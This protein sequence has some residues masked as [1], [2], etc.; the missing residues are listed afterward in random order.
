MI[1]ALRGEIRENLA[2]AWLRIRDL[3]SRSA[4]RNRLRHRRR[5]ALALRLAAVVRL[6]VAARRFREGPTSRH[7]GETRGGRSG[8][9]R[10]RRRYCA[11]PN[12]KTEGA[13][14]QPI[15]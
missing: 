4:R 13:L 14:Y 5:S 1:R 3:T 12:S 6:G 11:L 9:Q 7:R 2:L 10:S 8:E 15:S